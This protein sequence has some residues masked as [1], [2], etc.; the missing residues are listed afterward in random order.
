MSDYENALVR[1]LVD[2]YEKIG[3][4]YSLSA[5]KKIEH[6]IAAYE[7]IIKK[8]FGFLSADLRILNCFNLANTIVLN[9]ILFRNKEV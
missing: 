3:G 8:Q 6:E 1:C 5:E 4:F 7:K 9:N 2:L